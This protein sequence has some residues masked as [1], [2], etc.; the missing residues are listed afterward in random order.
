M[1]NE[2]FQ[3]VTGQYRRPLSGK[4]KA[5]ILLGELGGSAEGIFEHLTDAEV[6]KLRKAMRSLGKKVHWADETDVLAEANEWGVRK[7]IAKPVHSDAEIAA[8]VKTAERKEK[9]N[10]FRTMFLQNP[11]AIANALGAWLKEDK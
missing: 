1:A 11:D 8:L 3:M 9:E 7:G 6:K 10:E 2:P 5:A 4:E